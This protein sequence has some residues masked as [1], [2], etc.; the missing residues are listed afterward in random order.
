MTR[1]GLLL[2]ALIPTLR[3]AAQCGPGFMVNPYGGSQPCIRIDCPIGEV[4]E[5]GVCVR[6]AKTQTC[7]GCTPGACKRRCTEAPVCGNDRC[8]GLKYGKCY[9]V[10]F[11]DGKQLV[12]QREAP[13][14]YKKD[15]GDV[16]LPADRQ[17]ATIG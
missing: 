5:D 9:F 12:R 6:R 15:T 16:V 2:A 1:F 4:L 3:V 17:I 14:M 8:I 7:G 10:E 11:P 13:Y